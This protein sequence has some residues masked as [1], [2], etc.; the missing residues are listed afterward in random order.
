VK[1]F[2]LK[3]QQ[4]LVKSF[5]R[6]KD[7]IVSGF[8]HLLKK[9]FSLSFIQ[10]RLNALSIDIATIQ[11]KERLW[12]FSFLFTLIVYLVT[13]FLQATLDLFLLFLTIDTILGLFLLLSY[14]Y[15]QRVKKN[16]NLPLLRLLEIASYVK[17]GQLTE[18][19]GIVDKSEMGQVA[20]AFDSVIENFSEIIHMVQYSTNRT[21][22]GTEK[23]SGI[24]TKI[25]TLSQEIV[26]AMEEISQGTELQTNINDTIHERFLE[27][28]SLFD[29]LEEQQSLIKENAMI[30]TST[31][32]DSR[33]RFTTLSHN[34]QEL[35]SFAYHVN[36]ELTNF[37]QYIRQISS[38]AEQIH[39]ITKQTNLLALN[40]HI[41]AARAGEHGK[42][43]AVVAEEV[44]KLAEE[45]FRSSREIED[46]SQTIIY[47]ISSI[48]SQ[49]EQSITYA[50]EGESSMHASDKDLQSILKD[51]KGV[52]SALALTEDMVESQKSRLK[53]IEEISANSTSIAVETSANTE[54]V[55]ATSMS[56]VEDM[57]KV[58]AMTKKLSDIS[59]EL[60]AS[61]DKYKIQDVEF[62]L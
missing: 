61:T 14:T 16:A 40:A 13:V 56:F 31:I 57:K 26:H 44:R 22:K 36:E 5:Q 10:K 32:N 29:S 6:G 48:Q 52:L 2:F 12:Y 53:E 35:A 15:I 11:G 9:L 45:S 8:I 41:E 28:V 58:A 21:V 50:K 47:S 60:N 1:R 38:I 33:E 59:K 25:K 4:M 23:L 18:R 37:T 43:F 55:Y 30:T 24:S 46:I 62:Y 39:H 54:Q 27:L 20:L 7:K 19:T 17:A 51:M 42:G 3:V 34:V 49:S